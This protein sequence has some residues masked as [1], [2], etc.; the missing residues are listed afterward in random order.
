[1]RGP[2]RLDDVRADG[3]LLG[4]LQLAQSAVSDVIVVIRPRA[5]RVCLPQLHVT[6][7]TG[8]MPMQW[9]GRLCHYFTMSECGP[10]FKT[11]PGRGHPRTAALWQVQT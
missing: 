10:H 3:F 2:E 8:V 6:L 7:S 11:L 4:E 5:P 9:W 1:M